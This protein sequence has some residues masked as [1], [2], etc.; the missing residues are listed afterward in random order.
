MY[1]PGHYLGGKVPFFQQDKN[2]YKFYAIC[3]FIVGLFA[4]IEFTYD[5]NFSK[6][7]FWILFLIVFLISFS[8]FYQYYKFKRS[9]K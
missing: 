6:T 7:V 4:L 9:R 2:N 1:N 8:L 3:N 5:R